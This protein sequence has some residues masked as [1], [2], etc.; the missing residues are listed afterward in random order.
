L[1]FNQ[2]REGLWPVSTKGPLDAVLNVKEWDLAEVVRAAGLKTGAKGKVNAAIKIAGTLENPAADIAFDLKGVTVSDIKQKLSPTDATVKLNLKNKK[3]TASADIMYKPL[4]TLHATTTNMPLDVGKLLEKPDTFKEAPL[5][6]EVTLPD[7]DLNALKPFVSE[8]ASI[9]GKFG[10]NARIRGTVGKP[11][12]TGDMHANSPAITFKNSE[13]PAIRNATVRVKFDGT[14]VFIEQAG[15]MMSGGTLGARGTVDWTDAGNPKVDGTLTAQQ[16]LVVRD[17]SVSMRA[18]GVV[19][20]RGTLQQANVTGRVE[21]VRGRIYKEIEFL[22]LSLPN[23]LPPAP[24]P[25]TPVTNAPPSLPAPFD[26]WTFDV[27]IV[28]R[29]PVR[30][31]GNVLSGGAVSTLKLTGTGAKMALE[32]KVSLQ[33]A[34]VR[35]PFSRLTVSRGEVLFSKD[36]PFEPI[37][38]L[39][40]D[41][42]VNGYQVTLNAY[43]D[44]L[45]PKIRFSSSPPLP[46][47]EI[48]TLLAT[49]SSSGDLKSGEGQAANRAAFLVLSRAYRKL[50]RKR[51][52]VH[53]NDEPPRLSFSFSPLESGS[54]N[55]R[56]FSALYE[57]NEHLQAVGS[58]SQRGSFRGLLYYL[59]RFR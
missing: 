48:A 30:F 38:D 16:A 18:D 46:E 21:L 47:G 15:A 6:V 4:Q 32:G 53:E 5:S 41:S 7:S 49:G 54:G 42:F 52:L 17:D 10:V 37:L 23:Q 28:T 12:I 59:I 55:G 31:L 36:K 43:G 58:M 20:C 26:K 14:R 13:I 57:I 56:S 24:P 39:Q 2:P 25:S 27:D 50:F 35:L 40:G 29:E 45:D 19:A 1:D 3:L 22:P 9:S 44:A 51:A 34:R 11:H 8:V 33:D